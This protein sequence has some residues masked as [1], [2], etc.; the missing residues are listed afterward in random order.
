MTVQA[1]L[2]GALADSTR[3]GLPQLRPLLEGL[4]GIE[5][6]PGLSEKVRTAKLDLPAPTASDLIN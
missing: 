5:V 6:F 2:E 3:R 1:W 4:A